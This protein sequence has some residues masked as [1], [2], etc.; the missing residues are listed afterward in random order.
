[1]E[2]LTPQDKKN[3]RIASKLLRVEGIDRG[4]IQ[5]DLTSYYNSGESLEDDLDYFNNIRAYGSMNEV[6]DVLKPIFK[7]LILKAIESTEMSESENDQLYLMFD[8]KNQEI[9]I[10]HSWYEIE[11]NESS[12]ISWELEDENGTEDEELKKIFDSLEQYEDE[13]DNLLILRYDGSGDSGYLEGQFEGGYEVPAIVEDYCADLLSI[14]FGG[15]EINEGSW[16]EFTFDLENKVIELNHTMREEVEHNDTK[17]E[18]SF[19]K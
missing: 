5:I 17:F 15:W 8:A 11:D 6:P 4:Q 3:L 16:G 13:S 2:Q 18:E 7:K 10:T 1:M 19:A 12:G 14:N 9:T